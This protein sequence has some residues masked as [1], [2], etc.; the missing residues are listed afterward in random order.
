M[1]RTFEPVGKA[2]AT[3][4]DLAPYFVIEPLLPGSTLVALLL[5][6]S[7][8]FARDGFANIRQYSQAPPTSSGTVAADR[9]QTPA[10]EGPCTKG[11][12]VVAAWRDRIVQWCEV[13]GAAQ[14]CCAAR[15]VA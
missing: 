14:R 3:L 8:A 15:L 5:W 6:L 13:V 11:C 9:A 1:R 10:S 4:R 7:H 2:V 12:A